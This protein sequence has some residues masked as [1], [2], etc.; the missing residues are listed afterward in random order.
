MSIS[1]RRPYKHK[2]TKLTHM[3][4]TRMEKSTYEKLLKL[5]QIHNKAFNQIIIELIEREHNEISSISNLTPDQLELIR[6]DL[7]A[8][9]LRNTNKDGKKS[10]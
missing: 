6:A 3:I 9:L 2:S 10:I 7:E 4:T 5:R 8:A 1:G